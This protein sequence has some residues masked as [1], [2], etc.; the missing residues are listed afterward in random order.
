MDK[1]TW[2]REDK[3]SSN[4]KGL[5]H[6]ASPLISFLSLSLSLLDGVLWSVS[7][8]VFSVCSLSVWLEG[9]CRGESHE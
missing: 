9:G 4:E 5:P 2:L 6:D 1:E 3:R 8:V 7:E